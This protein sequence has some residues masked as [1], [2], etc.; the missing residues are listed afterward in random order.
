MV[1]LPL[2]A[3][4]VDMDS[5]F[6]SV[7]QHLRPELRGKAVGVAPVMA[8]SSCCIAA[9][10]EAKAFGVRTGTGI[11]EARQLCKGIEIV[12]A[13]PN[14]YVD[15]HHQ[16][17]NVVESCIHVD[18]VL[19][20]DEMVC[21]L[22]LNW[23][24][25]DFVEGIGQQIKHRLTETFS[26]WIRA[27]VG[28]A[29]NGWLAKIASAQ[30]KPNGLTIWEDEKDL[31]TALFELSLTDLY[32]VG[33]NMEVRLHAHGIHSISQLY[34]LSESQLRR[35][36]GNVEGGRLWHKLRGISIASQ[37]NRKRTLGHSHVL[38]PELRP[39]EK[40][41]TVLHKLVQ[42]AAHRMR[43]QGLLTGRLSI[44]VR[45]INR[46][47]WQNEVSFQETSDSLFFAKITSRLWQERPKSAP[48]ILKLGITFS[49]LAERGNYTPSLFQEY[50]P[51]ND[52]VSQVLDA[53][54]AK[55]GKDALYIATSH[56]AR[57]A[58]PT[59]IAFNHIP[60]VD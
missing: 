29:P 48:D 37:E 28:A 32:G 9:S 11:S 5:Y 52:R 43:N 56:E 3:L 39:P 31:P 1:P 27:S 10:Y 12:E 30:N 51:N 44:H 36:W 22:P 57:Q 40:A 18:E 25:R 26:P 45:F 46:T 13:R 34:D 35:V 53:V 59:R 24:E 8:E 4:F 19:S 16:I 38:S 20:I 21:W 49:K 15:Y 50:D 7:E 2:T 60:E 55:H 42:K 41:V 14:L 23:R 17:I 47:S 6:A 58:A 33:R 54:T